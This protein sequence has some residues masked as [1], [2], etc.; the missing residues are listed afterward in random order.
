LSNYCGTQTAIV[1]HQMN[2][3]KKIVGDRGR[4]P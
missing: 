3:L 1:E 4:A 2:K